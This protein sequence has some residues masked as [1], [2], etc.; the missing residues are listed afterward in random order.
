[1]V[2]HTNMHGKTERVRVRVRVRVI[3][4]VRVRV[5]R[6]SPMRF[7]YNKLYWVMSYLNR[8]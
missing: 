4:R 3:V 8:L 6:V 7:F 5:S 2:L 1:M